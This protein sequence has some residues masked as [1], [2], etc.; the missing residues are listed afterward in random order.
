MLEEVPVAMVYNGVSHAVL[1][2]TRALPAWH[3]RMSPPPA[4]TE[5]PLEVRVAAEQ[6]AW[7]IHYPGPDGRFEM[8]ISRCSIFNPPASASPH[9]LRWR[10]SLYK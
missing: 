4:G 2:A 9:S 7:H 1:L 8:A 6:F 5:A 10:M 3:A